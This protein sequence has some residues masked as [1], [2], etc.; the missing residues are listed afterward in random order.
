MK[1]CKPQ[2]QIERAR[3]AAQIMRDIEAAVCKDIKARQRKGVVKYGV[4]VANNSLTQ[5]EWLTH[6]YEELLDAAIYAKRQLV[7]NQQQ[8]EPNEKQNKGKSMLR[9]RNNSNGAGNMDYL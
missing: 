7:G 6:L 5:R 1:N 9:R 3:D 2:T 8:K 4:T